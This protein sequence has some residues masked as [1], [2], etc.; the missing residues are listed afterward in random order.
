MGALDII[1]KEGE[2][3]NFLCGKVEERAQISRFSA[4]SRSHTTRAVEIK[5]I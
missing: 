2:G 1:I 4:G 5:T 3:N